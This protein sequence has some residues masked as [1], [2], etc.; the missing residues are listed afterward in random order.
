MRKFIVGVDDPVVYDR[1]CLEWL[2]GRNKALLEA[3]RDHLDRSSWFQSELLEADFKKE[4]DWRSIARFLLIGFSVVKAIG[5]DPFEYLGLWVFHART[6]IIPILALNQRMKHDAPDLMAVNELVRIVLMTI[7]GQLNGVMRASTTR[8]LAV[9]QTV[10]ARCF[11]RV[12]EISYEEISNKYNRSSLSFP[13][14]CLSRFETDLSPLLRSS[15]LESFVEG[16]CEIEGIRLNDAT[17]SRDFEKMRQ[18]LDDLGDMRSD[19]VEG[20]LTLPVLLAL[21]RRRGEGDLGDLIGQIWERG[22]RRGVWEMEDAQWEEI[23]RI[24]KETGSLESVRRRILAYY[25]CCVKSVKDEKF[26]GDSEELMCLMELK[27][28]YLHRLLDNDLDDV[29][30]AC[31]F[32]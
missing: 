21:H 32:D 26:S 29:E 10:H 20:R 2:H 31:S 8:Q 17:W 25:E 13:E 1:E 3:V 16:I 14:P 28:A 5:K 4:A 9:W 18:L 12:I 22:K 27:K 11:E 7:A 15:I 6:R 30:P 24:V 19:I 23:K